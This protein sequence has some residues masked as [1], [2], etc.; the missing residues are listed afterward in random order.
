MTPKH[1]G[2]SVLHSSVGRKKTRPKKVLAFALF[3]SLLLALSACGNAEKVEAEAQ[4]QPSGA[5]RPESRPAAVDVAIARTGVLQEPTTYVGTTRP[6]REVSLRSQVEGRLLNLAVNIGDPVARGQILAQ[7]DEALLLTAVT[8]AEAELAARQSEV[9]R[10][11]TQVSNAK[12]KAEQA[13]LESQQSKVDTKR[14]QF[15]YREGAIS[16]QDAELSQTA[17]RTAEQALRAA[18]EQIRTE[19]QAVAAAQ[20]R[21]K[22]QQAIVAQARERKSYA[23]VTSPIKGVVLERV[24]EPGNLVQ[25]GGEIL[26]LGDFS[27]VK[28][29]VYLSELELSNIREGQSVQVRLDAFPNS[30]FSGTVSRISPAAEASS[31][32]V[33]IEIIIPNNNDRIGSG[34]LARVTFAQL[35]RPKTIVPQTALSV[36]GGG[37]SGGAGERG[38]AEVR[39]QGS[40]GAGEQGSAGVRERGSAGAGVRGSVSQGRVPDSESIGT[41]F[42][43]IAEGRQGTVQARRVLLGDRAN[44]RVEILSGL[45]PGE[46]YVVRSEKPLKD[47]DAVR[48]SVLSETGDRREQQ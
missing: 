22:A 14:R 21:V 19:E 9:A 1:S 4:S 47:G 5:A 13:R 28:V 43:A 10:A 20:G 25:P 3:P 2:K 15:L 30:P 33:P 7:L 40:G 17:A 31:R 48:L 35:D 6:I 45:L 29:V 36:A 8:Q 39:E 16:Q 38:S 27:S 46:R 41:I 44:G 32:Q 26:R 24:T 23:R 42:V 11:Q 34:L 18:E 37:R 12:A